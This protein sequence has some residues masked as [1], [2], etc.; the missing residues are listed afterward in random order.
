MNKYLHLDTIC[1]S[2]KLSTTSYPF[3]YKREK[4]ETYE[5]GFKFLLPKK[6]NSKKKDE[7]KR[8]N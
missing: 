1:D 8:K 7:K 3:H 4:D 6:N 2:R 5:S